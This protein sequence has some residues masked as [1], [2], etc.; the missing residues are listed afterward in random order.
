MLIGTCK[1]L[2]IK[3][4]ELSFQ[5][6][7]RLLQDDTIIAIDSEYKNG[8]INYYLAR[9]IRIHNGQYSGHP[10]KGIHQEITDKVLYRL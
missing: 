6:N 1:R 8:D 4:I 7:D 2:G 3:L 10:G 9:D 5:I